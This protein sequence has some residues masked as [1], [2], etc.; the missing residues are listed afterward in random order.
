M[1]RQWR[2]STNEFIWYLI[3][4][5]KEFFTLTIFILRRPNVRK[6]LWMFTDDATC[7]TIG[8]GAVNGDDRMSKACCGLVQE[9]DGAARI[10]IGSDAVTWAAQCPQVAG[11]SPSVQHESWRHSDRS[12]DCLV[13]LLFV[14]LAY[15]PYLTHFFLRKSYEPL[16]PFML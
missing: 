16:K 9:W 13:L 1:N 15:E 3:E 12:V 5:I 11:G 4:R 10:P 14:F 6:L 8:V 7:D 2:Y